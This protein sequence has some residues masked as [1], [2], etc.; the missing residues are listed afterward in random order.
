MSNLGVDIQVI[1]KVLALFLEFLCS[2]SHMLVP[3]GCPQYVLPC[4]SSAFGIK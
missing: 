2:N 1:P 3:G 4:S